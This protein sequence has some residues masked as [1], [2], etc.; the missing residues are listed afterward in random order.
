V[1]NERSASPFQWWTF[2][3]KDLRALLAK[4]ERKALA[5]AA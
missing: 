5:L 3:R 4:L 2:T 1:G